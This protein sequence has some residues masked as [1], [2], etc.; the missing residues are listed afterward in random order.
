M[1]S[2]E[3]RRSGRKSGGHRKHSNGAL[4]DASS[5][6]SFLDET[7]RE[8]SSLT[9][10]AFRSLCI[11][12]EAVYNDS[13]LN[14][15]SPCFQSD[16]QRAFSQGG[17]DGEREE[18]KR[19]AQESF[20]LRMHQYGQ[21]WMQ[22]GMY[23]AQV[24]RD[25]QCGLYG[26]SAQLSATF[27]HSFVNPSQQEA[28]P[29]NTEL[30]CL[31]NGATE[32]SLQQRRSRSRVSSLIQAF[33][34]EGYMDGAGS[35]G[36]LREWNDQGVWDRS[37]LIGIQTDLTHFSTSYPQALNSGQ[38]PPTGPFSFQDPTLYSS[39]MAVMAHVNA[40]SPFIRSSH[41]KHSMSTQDNSNSNVFIHSEFS[42]FRVWKDPNHFPLQHG[43]VSGFWS[44]SEFSQWY[45]TPMYK[46]IS[47]EPQPQG[48]Y[49]FHE[50]DIGYPRSNVA[51]ALPPTAFHPAVAQKAVSV[52]KRCESELTGY[53]PHWKGPESLGANRL[54]PQRPS[55]ASPATEMSRRVQDTISSV[56]AFQQKMKTMTE[57]NAS[58]EM[59]TS[60]DNLIYGS[61]IQ[62]EA[63]T[64]VGGDTSTTPFSI[65]QLLTPFI[66]GHQ[67][68]GTSEVTQHPVSP[69]PVEHPPVRAESRGVAPD[70]R[71][72]SYKSRATSLLFNLKD[73][74]KRVKSTY[75]PNKFKAL[76]TLEKNRQPALHE[77]TDTV[78]D[79]PDDPEPD[80]QSPPGDPSEQ[81]I[82]SHQYVKQCY[83][84]GV[85]A[86][87][88]NSQPA[89]EHR[90]HCLQNSGNY[91]TSQTQGELLPHPGFTGL[92]AENCTSNQLANGQSFYEDLSSFTPCKQGT[93]NNAEHQGGD[94]YR[95]RPSYATT[96]TPRKNSHNNQ[97]GEYLISKA[98]PEEH[99]NETV[100]RE[101]TKVKHNYSNV[102]SQN[103]WR[104]ANNQDAENISLRTA[105]SPWKQEITLMEKDKHARESQRAAV[106]KEELNIQG[107]RGSGKNQQSRNQ[108]TEKKELREN[109]AKNTPNI[110]TM[111]AYYRQEQHKVLEDKLALEYTPYENERK[112]LMKNYQDFGDQQNSD[113]NKYECMFVQGGDQRQGNEMQS[114]QAIVGKPQFKQETL[115]KP[116]SNPDNASSPATAN[117]PEHSQARQ[118]TA[119]DKKAQ[120]AQA[121]LAE[122]QN[123]A[124]EVQ[125]G[126]ETDQ[127]ILA[128]R[129]S[130]DRAEVGQ[131][132]AELKEHE[133]IQQ[134]ITEHAQDK[135]MKEN[136]P[137]RSR[138]Q[139]TMAEH[140]TREEPKHVAEETG[141]KHREE[142][143]GETVNPEQ[144]GTERQ[145][146][147][148][149][150]TEQTR[151][152][153]VQTEQKAEQVNENH[154]REQGEVEQILKNVQA[155]QAVAESRKIEHATGA[156]EHE[157]TKA[158]EGEFSPEGRVKLP[159]AQKGYREKTED[160]KAESP[161]LELAKALLVNAENM[162]EMCS[163]P[164]AKLK[165]TQQVKS[166]PDKVEQVKT[167]L[168]KAKAELAKIK[169][170]MREE[171]KEKARN[172]APTKDDG[173]ELL[174]LSLNKN[175]AQKHQEGAAQSHQDSQDSAVVSRK[176]RTDS[177]ADD[178][179]RLRQKYGFTNATSLNDNKMTAAAENVL[180]SDS[181][182][183][184]SSSPNEYEMRKDENSKDKYSPKNRSA[185][186][187]TENKRHVD[188]L[189]PSEGTENHYVYSESSK[190]FKLSNDYDLL[191][192]KVK[193]SSVQ[194]LEKCDSPKHVLKQEGSD[195][196]KVLHRDRKNKSAEHSLG[197]ANDPH[198]T[199]AR[200]LSHKERAQTKQ[201]IL[202]SRIK[203]H[204]EKE[205]SAIKESLAKPDSFL[206]KTFSRSTGVSQKPEIGRSP[207]QEVS[208][209]H[210]SHT[211][212]MQQMEPSGAHMKAVRSAT[213]PVQSAAAIRELSDPSKV[214][215]EAK[216]S[217]T[218]IQAKQTI[219][220]TE[221]GFDGN[222]M[223]KNKSNI[224]SS[225]K[226]EEHKL[227]NKEEN[228]EGTHGEIPGKQKKTLGE[229]SPSTANQIENNVD[230]LES[231]VLVKVT[232]P[233]SVSREKAEEDSAPSLKI[234][235][236]QNETP[237]TDDS[238]QIMGIMVTV[239]ERTTPPAS[240]EQR[241]NSADENVNLKETAPSSAETDH[242]CPSIAVEVEG[243]LKS[244]DVLDGHSVI[245]AD[246]P[247]AG[248]TNHPETVK[249]ISV[250]VSE[251]VQ[252]KCTNMER[253]N[254]ARPQ[255][256]T[257]F[258]EPLP[259]EGASC[260]L[261][262]KN[263][264][265]D[266]NESH[267]YK[268]DMTD[269]ETQGGDES[270]HNGENSPQ[271]ACVK[272]NFHAEPQFKPDSQPSL[273]EEM[274]INPP[275][276]VHICGQGSA[277]PEEQRHDPKT[278]TSFKEKAP[279]LLT[280]T[281]NKHKYPGVHVEENKQEEKVHIDSITIRVLPAEAGDNPDAED[282]T[283]DGAPA[284]GGE[285]GKD[286]QADK[287]ED[288]S[289]RVKTVP[290]LS[291]SSKQQ[292][293]LKGEK[294]TSESK[295]QPM[296][297]GYFQM[298]GVI[299]T[300]VKPQSCHNTED[301]C[302]QALPGIKKAAVSA[303]GK[304]AVF[305]LEQAKM[306][307]LESSSESVEDENMETKTRETSYNVPLKQGGSPS[308][309]QS[310]RNTQTDV[311][312]S[313]PMTAQHRQHR[314]S[315]S[316][317]EERR[318]SQNQFTTSENVKQEVKT[319]PK[320]RTSTI[321]EIS[322]IADY[323]RLKVIVSEDRENTIQEFP[324]HKK[325]GF[326]PLIQSHHSRRPVFTAEPQTTAAK[327]RSLPSKPEI[328]AKVTKEP[329]PLV[330]PITEKEHQRTGMF[331]LG[332]KEKQEKSTVVTKEKHADKTQKPDECASK[333]EPPP[334]L[335]Q[336]LHPQPDLKQMDNNE[337]MNGSPVAKTKDER[338][339]RWRQREKETTTEQKT[340]NWT[341]EEQAPRRNVEDKIGEI[342]IKQMIA[343][344]KA[345][346]E[347]EERRA[348]QRE[349]ERRARE[350]EATAILI[351]QRREKQME[352]ER[353]AE[354][355]KRVKQMEEERR[356]REQEAVKS[357]EEDER[358]AKFKE[359]EKQKIRNEEWSN[360]KKHKEERAAQ[361][362]HQG[363]DMLLEEQQRL[364]QEEQQRGSA[365][366]E[367]QR[368]AAHLEE[369]QRRTVQ[370][371]RRRRAAYEEQQRRAATQKQQFRAAQ[372]EEQQRQA[373][374]RE[375]QDR[376][377]G[378]KEQQK[379]TGEGQQRRAAG[380][381]EQQIS[382]VTE[383]Q[384]QRAAQV[385]QRLRSAEEE[386]QKR[387]AQE[388]RPRTAEMD[389][390]QRRAACVE[391]RRAA[392][393]EEQERAPDQEH[394]RTM[395]RLEE[396]RRRA[397][398]EKQ[399][400][401]V[402]QNAADFK[403]QRITPEKVQQKTSLKGECQMKTAQ[404]YE[405]QRAALEEQQ[406]RAPPE[407]QHCRTAKVEQQRKTAKE[408]QQQRAAETK[409]QQGSAAQTE[410]QKRAAKEQQP[411]RA[412]Q[413][414]QRRT[415]LTEQQRQA[416]PNISVGEKNQTKGREEGRDAQ[417][418]E[419]KTN[420][421]I[422]NEV[423]HQTEG[424]TDRRQNRGVWMQT[425][426]EEE[427]RAVHKM[428][429]II[430][431]RE[432]KEAKVV[433]S[434]ILGERHSAVKDEKSA[435]QEQ[436]SD[437]RSCAITARETDEEK[438]MFAAYREK[439]RA[440]RTEQQKRAAQLIDALQ[441]YTITS[442]ESERKA[443]ERQPSS[444]VPPQHRNH[445]PAVQS[446]EDPHVKL[447]RPQAPSSPAPSLP[448]SN[449]SSPALGNKP[450]MFRVKDNTLRGSSFV[451][452][453]KPRFHKAFGDDFRVSSPMGSKK[454]EEE[455]D[456]LRSSAV[457]PLHLDTGSNRLAA[458][459]DSFP[460]ACSSQGSSGAV[461]HHRP[462]SR[463]SFALD[464]DDS[465]SVF[466]IM[467][468][469][470]ESFATSAADLADVRTLCEY[471]RPESSCSF[472]SD[473]SRSLGKP[474]VVPPKSEK[475][476]RRAKRL[477]T[478]RIEKE[479]SKAVA[480]NAPE[481]G[482][483][484]SS[485]SSAEVQSS[486]RTA[487]ATP[488]SSPPVSL[489]YAPKQGS[490]LP[491]S[492]AEHQSSFPATPHATGPISLPAAPSHAAIS[493]SLP[494]ASP[495][496]V[497][498]V[499]HATAPKTIANVPSSPTLHHTSHQ[500]PVAKF[501]FESS[502]PNSYP[503]T[504][505]K[506]LQD[507]GSGQYFV[508]DMPVQVRTKTFFDP[509]T[510]RYVQLN[511]RESARRPSQPQL[512]QARPPPQLQPQSVSRQH[513][514]HHQDPPDVKP[515]VF[516]QGYHGYQQ[517]YQ[518]A[519]ISTAPHSRSSVPG[520]LYHDQQP[521]RG[522]PR[523]AP[524][525]GE[526]GQDSE[527][528]YYSPEKTPYMDT[529]N[530]V[531]RNY[532][533]LYDT[534]ESFP[535]GDANSQIAGSSV[536]KNDNSAHSQC[537]SRDI[538]TMSELEDFMELSD[539]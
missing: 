316:K 331:K 91:Q 117:Q 11:G 162:L 381:K 377:A 102:S 258:Q 9:D 252:E 397:A 415:V 366:Q 224:I 275:K 509:E 122:A 416:E 436:M 386:R 401:R 260:I 441:Y 101:P 403:E 204:A 40:E 292:N 54:P 418:S 107:D 458:V 270:K 131:T 110:L 453:V 536:Y 47:M 329:K 527:E 190:E 232:K 307:P 285:E 72:S 362:D 280:E 254:S 462:Y 61:D 337:K 467:S 506:V 439:E 349:E 155:G 169:E 425:Q 367:Q 336:H 291:K 515:G 269:R 71:T 385:E 124:Q 52:E 144:A 21:N 267:L 32:L 123:K 451:K 146:E 500:A 494:A 246:E 446:P 525:A 512:Q 497:G 70:V 12:D 218:P 216:V 341:E 354:E 156:G 111:P 1:T 109:G 223:E 455:Q 411:R 240:N 53:H 199:P 187:K 48:H 456:A 473:M 49:H 3:K 313:A 507:I 103:R 466:S 153:Q 183:T 519:D 226:C 120:H 228:E 145:K 62:K 202:T 325:E 263:K 314:A 450:S 395:A 399:Q 251:N 490:S 59:Q 220:S 434:N 60:S 142:L 407:E 351:K 8:V 158:D 6:G 227:K 35:D 93:M 327:E 231:Q 510:G 297:G 454:V 438:E 215:K 419:E 67:E 406:K 460:P 301:I 306:K 196:A 268:Q 423:E 440:A 127:I 114:L 172:R 256:E 34:T 149:M 310:V 73:N 501:Q 384:Q 488:H 482:S 210:E 75:S 38:F 463:R 426:E 205:I 64:V 5:T 39:E 176:N 143:Q 321:P 271:T 65:S 442:A 424:K 259:E 429:T 414:E 222:Q 447:Y 330:F 161:R 279:H 343:E 363:R 225:V 517:G 380:L 100:G 514:L 345:S 342:K 173:K 105:I 45:E 448:R 531:D 136:Q 76:E 433:S 181:S 137:E 63:L 18:I 358:G 211:V 417:R 87:P 134:N 128:E 464:E 524:A 168:A 85:S 92:M 449:A 420:K 257:L 148:H 274:I 526:M 151:A 208:K 266:V 511:V 154:E 522:N 365:E 46:Q 213:A 245:R 160:K 42:P 262:A 534:L 335:K 14:S 295:I 247:R 112:D 491:S 171:Q 422:Q 25:P 373:V 356:K 298:Q 77:H 195:L 79:I 185:S 431:E 241:K 427:H 186:V 238:L 389:G 243:R 83:T 207:S 141:A 68:A 518:A 513:E 273:A 178:Y 312:K 113:L 286:S 261:L 477:T 74:R 318:S 481:E 165:I 398:E 255:W 359:E 193:D 528:H 28:Q 333:T 44:C 116:L 191:I 346:L 432:A 265:T 405:Q 13:D 323:A 129:A 37:A 180:P 487:V 278:V 430:K 194:K 26:E 383:E 288:V 457:T 315:S 412:A 212:R 532:N 400:H 489:A 452:S 133:R 69:Q 392:D 484:I 135:K 4:S 43:D 393:F 328:R 78:I 30:S 51:P 308:E 248:V 201:E 368:R 57:Q 475:A 317:T 471:E 338:Q 324:P 132:K 508:V 166:E 55:T 41:S 474:P 364:S 188:S 290:D 130:S 20:S 498:P 84:S 421:Q 294:I 88:F 322:A 357:M 485:S 355:E 159:T 483:A 533:T 118:A 284:S 179:E 480:E 469:D 391:Q 17:P 230:L 523:C 244:G 402:A 339:G 219:I 379:G 300:N 177:G 535:E 217:E 175:E 198:L 174:K 16:R 115:K 66:A 539:W 479:L 388:H 264:V 15:S 50:R 24:R 404:P 396:Q 361:A 164:V 206:S 29:Q 233:K 443:R 437:Q 369:L 281:E 86:A 413:E 221:E 505:R 370:E 459:K 444:P 253:K 350:R 236:G 82:I 344:S 106:I 189:T 529:A 521:V 203:A 360:L 283:K 121:E 516:Q 98:N 96:E 304:N 394:Q 289:L 503:L 472:S 293:G 277:L 320:G 493:V 353:R 197:P 150:K 311:D 530:D 319:K 214:P 167:E 209:K 119:E 296:E 502:Y 492:L 249:E 537:G 95:L 184:R 182:K 22:G 340:A 80:I 347:E 58:A 239:R 305:A 163:K 19:A 520:T 81:N 234:A 235:L 10:R 126:A 374:Q 410:Q 408:E 375:H 229:N 499:P 372:L 486:S 157:K 299:K 2:V 104:Q 250:T 276:R 409:K 376:A 125:L 89:K 140:T 90:G 56:K 170:K 303:E 36:K 200:S 348:A 496:A 309:F 382:A 478:R 192:S 445:L 23:G 139:Q 495:H 282:K 504:Q 470:V 538:I 428:K 237:A 378:N 465:R 371:E 152:E 27:Q 435:G 94:R 108:E 302:E 99:F 31:S 33:N 468:E 138:E 287:S 352:A 334:K 461:Q 97:T 242:Y 7:D 332:E 326:F 272:N 147:E 476:L 387:A 390:R